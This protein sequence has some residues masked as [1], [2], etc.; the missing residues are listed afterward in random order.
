MVYLRSTH[1]GVERLLVRLGL[2]EVRLLGGA[3]L[4]DQVGWWREPAVCTARYYGVLAPN[5]HPRKA[6]VARVERPSEPP[7]AIPHSPPEELSI[8]AEFGWC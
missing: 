2:L 6:V 7:C 8:G 4:D 3:L 5:A 1:A